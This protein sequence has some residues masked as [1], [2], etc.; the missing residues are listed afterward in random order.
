MS[1]DAIAITATLWLAFASP[2]DGA[3][4]RPAAAVSAPASP[5]MAEPLFA[6]I[7]ARAG[8][9]K[10]RV[11]G[12]KGQTGDLAGFGAFK[13]ELAALAELD[14]KAHHMLAERGTPF[15]FVSGSRR[16]DVPPA[17]Q[18]A[19]FLPKPYDPQD[20]ERTFLARLARQG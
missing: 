9:L 19:P 17:L 15:A 6:D 11:E 7:V 12:W 13:T 18:H 1:C 16:E 14:M 10:T 20:I 2:A 4:L 5:L 3:T 8:A